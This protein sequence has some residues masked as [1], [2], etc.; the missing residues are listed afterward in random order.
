[1]DEEIDRL[2]ENAAD[3]TAEGLRRMLNS[4]DSR[5]SIRSTL[6][7]RKVMARLVEIV[8]GEVLSEDGGSD[9]Y[10]GDG[11]ESAAA[12]EPAAEVDQESDADSQEATE[13]GEQPNA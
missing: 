8:K 13:S 2:M 3:E 10:A 11:E 9:D 5:E 6:L 7:N 12:D 4:E 1:M